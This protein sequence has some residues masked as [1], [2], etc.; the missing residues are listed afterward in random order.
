MTLYTVQ[1]C[2]RNY[3]SAQYR[4]RLV[5]TALLT[6]LNDGYG[7]HHVALPFPST[8]AINNRSYVCA[9]TSIQPSLS[10]HYIL[11]LLRWVEEI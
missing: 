2:R 8:T 11:H 5:H 4:T 9:F 6:K 7:S 10:K 3:E 1:R